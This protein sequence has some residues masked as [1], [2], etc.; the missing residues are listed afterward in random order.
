MP[1]KPGPLRPHE[2]R[3][4]YA[5]R[6]PREPAPGEP[7][8]GDS[9]L[10]VTE[11]EVTERRYFESLRETLQVNPV[12]VRVVHPSC[13]DAKGLVQAARDA[14]DDVAERRRRC[15]AGNTE[16]AGYDHV[17]VL[18]DTDVPARQGQLGPAL[19][20]ARKEGIRVGHSTPSV[21]L[22]LLLHFR[23]R[24][25]PLL[26]SAD[27]KRAVAEAWGQHYDKSAETFLKLWPALR[28]NIPAAV[29][30]AIQVREYHQKGETPSPANPSTEVDLLVRALDAS[31]QP[32]L[33]ILH[34][35]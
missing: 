13:T 34:W 19:D 8:P 18:F 22:W 33:R 27:A 16:V 31:V 7:K 20:L 14:R 9:F 24:P 26:N 11:G 2:E 12:T 35:K 15:Q 32:P 5:R 17:W 10:I 3:S 4:H 29:N 25:G 23:D 21:E 1:A 6:E 30:R 28:P